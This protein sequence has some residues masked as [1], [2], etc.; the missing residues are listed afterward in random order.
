MSYLEESRGLDPDRAAKYG[1]EEKRLKNGAE[2][3][4]IAYRRNGEVYGHKVRPI[5]PGDGPRFFF[6]PTGQTRDLWNA[7]VLGDETLFDHPVIVT[8]GELDAL[9]C[10]QAGFPRAVSIPD[11]WTV[12]YRGD[13]GPKSKPIL[14]NADRLKRSPYVIAAGDGDDTGASFVRALAN[15][16][17]HPV[18]YLAYPEGCK[19]A[20]DVL[21]KY[22]LGE[23]A[24]VLNSAK[25]CDPEGGL[26]SG[27]T[28]LPPEPPMQIYR[29]GYPPLDN[30]ILFHTGFPTVVTGIPGSG[31][32]TFVTCAIH[33]AVRTN[34][35]RAAFGMFETPS[36]VL[37]DHLSRLSEGTPWDFLPAA[38]KDEVAARL[39]R[40]YR[41]M[42][43]VEDDRRSHDMGWVRDMMHAAAVR[44][45]CKIVVFDPWNEIEHVPAQGESV[46]TYLNAALARIRQWAER[47][48][49]SV[50]I[51][52]HP[53]K[54]QAAPGA[55]PS[56]PL[57]YD[58]SDSAAWFN[59]AAIGVTVHQVEGKAEEGETP[60]VEVINW[61]SKFQQQYGIGKGKI[62]LDF[63]PRAMTY[64]GR[65]HA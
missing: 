20:N 11:G 29:P 17:D 64:R 12:A 43:K 50:V 21:R 54:M 48:D 41:V 18:K 2:A 16:L 55:K 37:R 61:K 3:V 47:F 40:N 62:V 58:I 30:V 39:D 38:K 42:H 60:H 34:N 6:H 65:L 46:T 28:D 57:G 49:C 15:L 1:V 45:G 36:S 51:V 7:D 44:D 22:G 31:K 24:R 32:S 56:P 10:I 26:V 8:E 59:K 53:T 14:A 9:S 35:I 27:F 63:D 52:A 25:W 23:L 4:T 5:N 19:D 33:H 13:D